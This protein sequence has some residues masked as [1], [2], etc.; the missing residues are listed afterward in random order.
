MAGK[1]STKKYTHPVVHTHFFKALARD[2]L[3]CGGPEVG[4]F[5]VGKEQQPIEVIKDVVGRLVDGAC[6]R[7]IALSR[8]LL[9][10]PVEGL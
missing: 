4:C 6:N 3:T 10:E 5:S 8:E 7:Y 2:W 9:Q 1:K